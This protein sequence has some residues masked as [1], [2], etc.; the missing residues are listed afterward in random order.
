MKFFTVHCVAIIKQKCKKKLD[1]HNFDFFQNYIENMGKGIETSFKWRFL[2]EIAMTPF[3]YCSFL[4]LR[5]SLRHCFWLRWTD[6]IPGQSFGGKN[7]SQYPTQKKSAASG[8]QVN[9]F[10]CLN[11]VS[12]GQFSITSWNFLKFF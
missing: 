9:R 6:R 4:T 5:C 12:F 8:N 3:S 7:N 2:A 11:F 1:H 10:F